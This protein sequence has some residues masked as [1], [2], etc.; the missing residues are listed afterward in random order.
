[1]PS[2]SPSSWLLPPFAPSA[3]TSTTRSRTSRDPNPIKISLKIDFDDRIED[4]EW[5]GHRKLSLEAGR[6]PGRGTL[7]REGLSWLLMARAGVVMGGASW[8]RVL[9][10]GNSIGVE[11][12]YPECSAINPLTSSPRKRSSPPATWLGRAWLLRCSHTPSGRIVGITVRP[13]MR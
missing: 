3:G 11:A 9:V 6:G 8:V 5:H 4:G 2:R 1:M 10:N 12:F 13:N 7:L